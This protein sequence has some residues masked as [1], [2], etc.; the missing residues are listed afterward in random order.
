MMP[1]MQKSL[2]GLASDE[3]RAEF[4]KLWQSRVEA[5]VTDS[6]IWSRIAPILD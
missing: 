6:A 4:A 3:E 5:M 2:Q 1:L